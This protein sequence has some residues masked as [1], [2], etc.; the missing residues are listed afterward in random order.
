MENT[1][2]LVVFIFIL[3]TLIAWI[4]YLFAGT[5]GLVILVCLGIV[6][7]FIIY[8]QADNILL[9][10]FNA[11]EVNAS[12][13]PYLYQAIA[14]LVERAHIPM[15]NVY[16]ISV[17]QPNAFVLGQSS[18]QAA[19][20]VTTQLLACLDGREL[21]A[22]LAHEIAHIQRN[23][24]VNSM[25]A[26]LIVGKVTDFSQKIN[27]FFPEENFLKVS[28]N[29]NRN[30]NFSKSLKNLLFVFSWIVSIIAAIMLH[31]IISRKREYLADQKSVELCQDPEALIK[32]LQ[33]IHHLTHSVHFDFAHFNLAS[34]HAL[35]VYPAYDEELYALYQTQ[36]T[37]EQRVKSLLVAQGK[38]ETA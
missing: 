7:A 36:P 28:K 12:S 19:L 27:D 37:V 2:R 6:Q 23:D 8:K 14:E 4:G 34:K 24:C 10:A 33:K 31:I 20:I 11:R 1:V 26:S 15:P 32:A 25:I 13:S 21:R 5:P 9:R 22:I 35:T 17:D 3:L 29:Q 16:E 38:A 18:R 30:K